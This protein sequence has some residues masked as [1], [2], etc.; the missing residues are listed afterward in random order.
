MTAAVSTAPA[1]GASAHHHPDDALLLAL[2]AGRLPAGQALV[3]T[4]HVEGCEHCRTR[5]H[6]LQAVGGAMLEAAPPQSLAPDAWARTLARIDALPAQDVSPLPAERPTD[7]P[8]LAW[9]AGVPWPSSLRGCDIS[10]WVWMGPSMRYARVVV[11]ADPAASI[12]LLRIGEGRSL[13][14]HTHSGVEL[15]QVLCGSFDDGRAIF[16]P[17]DFDEADGDVHHQPIV[18]P[19]AECICLA[20]VGAPL[21]F[22]GRIAS[23]IGGWVG[24]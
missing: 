9:P 11:P 23:W 5:L 7:T 13:P 21:R 8:P 12:F 2:A 24:L 20:Y 15:T 3:L 10:R 1:V 6:T 16:G 4:A 17:G 14:R 22:D 18:R 19:G